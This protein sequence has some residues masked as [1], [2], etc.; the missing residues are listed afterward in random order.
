ML[1]PLYS[2]LFENKFRVLIFLTLGA[3]ILFFKTLH[4]DYTYLDDVTLIKE[5]ESFLNSISSV[6][7]AFNNGVFKFSDAP[8]HNYYRPVLITSFIADSV[9]GNHSLKV[10]HSTN[11][12]IHAICGF[13]LFILL[14]QYKVSEKKA[15]LMSVLF[16]LH[17]ALNSSVAWIPGRNESLLGMFFLAAMN[18]QLAY[19]K[20]KKIIFLAASLSFSGICLFVKETGILCLI[21]L[22]GTTI[23]TLLT[24]KENKINIKEVL[25]QSGIL[26][27][28]IFFYMNKKNSA[29]TSGSELSFFTAIKLIYTNLYSLLQYTGKLLFPFHLS[30]YP[31]AIDTPIL[32]GIAGTM[33]F[34]FITLYRQSFK[35]PLFI[36]GITIFLFFMIPNALLTENNLEHRLY[37]PAIGT[38]FLF[39][40][41]T[42]FEQL[43]N[44]SNNVIALIIIIVFT[45]TST[46]NIQH[47]KNEQSFWEKA[48]T[49]SPHSSTTNM[50]LGT[51]YYSILDYVSAEKYFKLSLAADSLRKDVNNNLG[52]TY[53]QMSKW[54]NAEKAF[55]NELRINEKNYLAH[56]NLALVYEEVNDLASA[57]LHLNSC[58]NINPSYAEAITELGTLYA[59]EKN[60]KIAIPLFESAINI[61]PSNERA[62]KN[63]TLSYAATAQYEKAATYY[64]LLKEL[65]NSVQIPLLDSITKTNSA[66]H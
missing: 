32:Q 56:Y 55:L 22:S 17:P 9:I 1:Q 29:L 53:Y 34:A 26:I 4:F 60:F 62:I 5:N 11:I 20:S 2:Y 6:P 45:I 3:F 13:L 12:L 15:L 49:T 24:N 30:T 33:L 47:Y 35:N 51:Y 7:D 16:I 66:E 14:T 43:S 23:A 58:L 40:S 48:V 8:D 63:L 54:G 39:S 21:L 28:L 37:L 59:R 25:F 27:I 38:L 42:L 10:F 19:M 18:A 65:N 52:K 41:S 31:I 36:S 46:F 50:Q 61:D 64:N 57:K 44:K